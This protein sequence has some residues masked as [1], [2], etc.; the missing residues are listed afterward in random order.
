VQAEP[1]TAE[2][3]AAAAAESAAA[4]DKYVRGAV[5]RPTTDDGSVSREAWALQ[6]T[7]RRLWADQAVWTRNFL[8][9]AL[10]DAPDTQAASE[11]LLRHQ[12]DVGN[13]FAPFY[14]EAAGG[15]LSVSLTQ[16][17]LIAADLIELVR[18]EDFGER[19]EELDR[20][21]DLN[22]AHIARLLGDLNP[23][24]NMD[25]HHLL[26]Q[27]LALTR[28]WVDA[29]TFCDWDKDIAIFDHVM[30]DVVTLADALS[31]G[32]VKKFPDQF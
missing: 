17:T 28:Q 30:T 23:Q 18:L 5:A 29:R 26:S 21:W 8:V 19:F 9:A 32:I 24:W 2:R 14:G 22:A 20:K 13:A 1:T 7:M 10:S 6:R 15:E 16:H 25:V 4:Y 31:V 12:E 27:N 11:R 3:A